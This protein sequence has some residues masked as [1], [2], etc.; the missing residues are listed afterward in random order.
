MFLLIA[1][2]EEVDD[3]VD[4]QEEQNDADVRKGGGEH[5]EPRKFDNADALEQNG[6]YLNPKA[7]TDDDFY[8]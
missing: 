4:G 5:P 2:Q 7:P 6:N 8:S 1:K 3:Q